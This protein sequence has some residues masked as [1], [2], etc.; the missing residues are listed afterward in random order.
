MLRELVARNCNAAIEIA[1]GDP[2]EEVS[3]AKGGRIGHTMVNPRACPRTCKHSFSAVVSSGWLNV[4]RDSIH[5]QTAVS[6]H[7]VLN[8]V[9]EQDIP[10]WER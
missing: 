2:K 3:G 1:V 7:C 6:D 10:C 9:S 5:F 8:G 4:L